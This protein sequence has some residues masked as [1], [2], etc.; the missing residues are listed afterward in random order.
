MKNSMKESASWRK[1][2]CERDR[3]HGDGDG[4]DTGLNNN[5]FYIGQKSSSEVESVMN[6]RTCRE[7]RSNLILIAVCHSVHQTRHDDS[8]RRRQ[9]NANVV[10]HDAMGPNVAEEGAR[11]RVYVRKRMC[12][13][14]SR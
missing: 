3:P 12:V 1:G 6:K 5:S 2:A 9:V 7:E 13:C 8:Q 14:V 4:D 11:V 10:V